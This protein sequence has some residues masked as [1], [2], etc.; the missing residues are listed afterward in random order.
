V[1]THLNAADELARRLRGEVLRPSEDGFDAATRLW[2][3]MIEKRP[4]LVARPIDAADVAAV[5]RF[6]EE[7]DLPLSVRGGGHNIAGT[8]LTEGGLTIDMSGRRRIRVDPAAR[9]VT[10]E[11]GC[12]LGEVDRATQRHGLATPLGF[13][14]EVGVAGLTLGGGL[15]YLTRRFGWSVDNLLAVEIVTAD[16]RVRRASRDEHEDLFW[17]VRGAG[18]NLGAVTSLTFVLHDV[19]PTVVGGLIVWPFAMADELLSGYRE[20]TAA[21]PR[22]LAV[23]LSLMPAPALPVVPDRWHGREVCAMAVCFS[24]DPAEAAAALA[25]IR[26]LGEPIVDLIGEQPYVAVQSYLDESEPSGR[27]YH[28]RTEFLTELSDGLLAG[29]RDAFAD[30]PI[31]EGEIGILH[32]GGA[33]NEHAEDDG[34][35]GNRDARYV[36]GVKGMW[37]PAEPDAERF[38]RWVRDAAVELR[39]HTT[40][41]TY[42]NFQ[43]VDEPDER[44]R[45]S[46]GANYMRL[47]EIKQRYDPAN[48]FRSNRNVH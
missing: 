37:E 14:S 30:C 9:T 10:V 36:V 8:A 6:A 19:G 20:I 21:A 7:H 33:L 5:V 18:A 44:I 26:A 23:W 2:N 32:L 13:V 38:Q 46:Y 11:T 12:L 42:I 35:V 43:G 34:A 15:G 45:G 41:R 31:P 27:H 28:W 24:G 17:G 29:V 39:P 3:G 16:G 40:G 48:L 22:E 4:A 1:T 47:L 25:P